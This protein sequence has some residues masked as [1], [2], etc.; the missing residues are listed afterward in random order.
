MGMGLSF[1]EL[2]P[3]MESGH[4]RGIA[5]VRGEMISLPEATEVNTA[6]QKYPRIEHQ[7]SHR[8]DDPQDPPNA[9]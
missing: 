7:P 1:E 3:R 6:I 9:K 4:N 2:S 8:S 5:E